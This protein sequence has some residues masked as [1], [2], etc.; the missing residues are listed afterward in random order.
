MGFKDWVD[1]YVISVPASRAAAPETEIEPGRVP[2]QAT[3]KVGRISVDMDESALKAL[4]A[5]QAAEDVPFDKIFAAAKIPVPAHKFTVEKIAE[6]L[7]HPKLASLDQAGKAAAAL[8]ALESQG[9]TIQSV[10]EE[11]AKKDRALDV[12]E[13]VQR[14]RLRQFAR[15]KEEENRKLACEI[16]K[17][18]K[19]VA[20][21]ERSVEAWGEKKRLKEREIYD[22]VAH[23]TTENPITAAPQAPP[24]SGAPLREAASPQGPSAKVR[25][26]DLTQSA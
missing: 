22:V 5:A 1:R 9:V 15:Q 17:N 4:P 8:V 26:T 10:I 3:A 21:V 25:I 14:E 2:M 12:F 23:F 24:A 7:A 18:K 13:N 19:A 16:E 11:A 6:M 20:A